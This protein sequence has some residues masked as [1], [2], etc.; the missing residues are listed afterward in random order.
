MPFDSG[1]ITNFVF[2]RVRPATLSGP[3]VQAVPPLG[4]VIEIGLGQAWNR[5]LRDQFFE[6]A[7]MQIIE[8]DVAALGMFAHVIHRSHVHAAPAVDQGGPVGADAAALRPPDEV[9]DQAGAPVDDGAEH[10][11]DQGFDG[12]EVGHVRFLF[13]LFVIRGLSSERPQNPEVIGT[14]FRPR[15]CRAVLND[16]SRQSRWNFASSR[17]SALM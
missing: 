16:G 14:R 5:K 4:E 12:G 11:E 3:R 13:L 10:V 7:A 15:R 17:C 2:S 6:R 9:G 1:E 8:H